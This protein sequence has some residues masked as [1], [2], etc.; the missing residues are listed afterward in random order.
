VVLAVRKAAALTLTTRSL[1]ANRA[2]QAV[3]VGRT[4]SIVVLAVLG[5]RP[6]LARLKETLALVVLDQIHLSS[7]LAAEAALGVVAEH[8]QALTWL[9][10]GELG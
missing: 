3:A 1:A 5:T 7:A 2:A 8:P 9:V 10:L 4:T 6:P